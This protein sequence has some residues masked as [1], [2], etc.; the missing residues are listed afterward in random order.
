MTKEYAEGLT[1]LIG[2]NKAICP[3]KHSTVN[4]Y[5]CSLENL[6]PNNDEQ[7]VVVSVLCVYN[8]SVTCTCILLT[9]I[10]VLTCTH[11]FILA[12]TCTLC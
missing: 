12:V 2:K 4:E 9:C 7:I 1:V 8:I 6:T 11:I 10:Q 3:K 5:Y